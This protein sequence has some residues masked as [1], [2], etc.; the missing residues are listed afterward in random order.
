MDFEVL[1]E[2]PFLHPDP[3]SSSSSADSEPAPRVAVRGNA[4]FLA[5]LLLLLR[6]LLDAAL[7]VVDTPGELFERDQVRGPYGL[8]PCKGAFEAPASQL[9]RPLSSSLFEPRLLSPVSRTPS[10]LPRWWAASPSTHCTAA[11]CL[12][13]SNRTRASTA[14]CGR[15]K[16]RSPWWCWAPKLCCS[17]ASSSRST[18]RWKCRAWTRPTR[19]RTDARRW[20]RSIVRWGRRRR[21]PP[22]SPVPGA[23]SKHTVHATI[24]PY[25]CPI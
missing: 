13:T 22:P 5:E 3:S 15:C 23:S 10:L 16:K 2:D 8:A 24:A 12:R 1:Q 17:W 19:W 14:P 11:C 21:P 25:L 20:R 7:A 18:R 9:F 6:Q 4:T